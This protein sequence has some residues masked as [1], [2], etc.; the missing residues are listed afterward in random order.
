MQTMLNFLIS[1]ND[2]SQSIMRHLHNPESDT[3]IEIHKNVYYIQKV[4]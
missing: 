1:F 3:G 2:G 4:H